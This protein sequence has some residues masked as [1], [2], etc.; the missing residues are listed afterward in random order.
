MNVK[1]G[2][3]NALFS[4]GALRFIKYG[5]REV[6]S[7]IYFAVRDENWETQE[8]TV[9]N[10]KTETA[11]DGFKITFD[12]ICQKNDI[13]FRWKCQIT[14]NSSHLVFDIRGKAHSDFRKNRIGFCVLHPLSCKDS[15]T[16]ITHTNGSQTENRFPKYINPHQP[17]IDIKAM[18]WHS[19]GLQCRLAFEGDIFETEDQRNWSDAS[20]KTYCTPLELPFPVHMQPGD[21]V[22]QTIS[23]TVKDDAAA[24]ATQPR[25]HSLDITGD[26]SPI[27]PIGLEA[28]EETLDDLTV[29]RLKDL[30]LSHLRIEARTHEENWQQGFKKRMTQ[31]KQ[32]QLPVALVV[33]LK[34]TFLENLKAL[35][36]LLDKEIT[37]KSILPIDAKSIATGEEFLQSVLPEVR[38]LFSG[39]PAG[40]GTDCYFTQFNRLRPPF[41]LIDFVAF[42]VNPQVHAFDDMSMIENIQTLPD[43]VET[44]LYLANGLPVH[45]T[46]VTLKPRF[47]PDATT[48][49]SDE[50]KILSRLDHRHPVAFNALWTLGCLKQLAQSGAGSVTFFQTAGEEGTLMPGRSTAFA[51]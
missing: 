48:T 29:Q 40:G 34:E 8:Q 18:D 4:Q 16:T 19:T 9:Q 6:L 43:M 17:F 22:H 44:A 3:L 15:K 12:S 33:F 32:L 46:P 14:G 37:I 10:I 41:Q 38:K 42:S 23:L 7:M 45:I 20:F 2:K 31:A 11:A 47:N 39:V 28:N 50:Q 26:R 25:Q 13:D 30:N 5:H 35:H 36:D 27:P 24:A 21:E 1:A 51:Q 49:V